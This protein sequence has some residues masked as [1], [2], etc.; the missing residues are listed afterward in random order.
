M[1]LS[2]GMMSAVLWFI[3]FAAMPG[4]HAGP[5][6]PWNWLS[7]GIPVAIV[8]AILL[9]WLVAL[10]RESFPI[11]RIDQRLI[12]V[13]RFPWLRASTWSSADTAIIATP[14]RYTS[15]RTGRVSVGYHIELVPK[16]QARVSVCPMPTGELEKIERACTAFEIDLQVGEL[17]DEPD[18][19]DSRS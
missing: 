18:S 10:V 6:S 14:R 5:N 9:A 12:S 16:G 17:A 1:T 8:G 19:H 11:M 3:V 13:R 4:R 7:P 15:S 2:L